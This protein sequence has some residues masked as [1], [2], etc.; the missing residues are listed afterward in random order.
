MAIEDRP[1]PAPHRLAAV[2]ADAHP[3]RP[4]LQVARGAEHVGRPAD[5]RLR[6]ARRRPEHVRV[7]AHPGH[8]GEVPVVDHADV[9]PAETALQRDL[10]AGRQVGGE[11]EVGGEEVAGAGRQ[12]R[13]RRLGADQRAQRRHHRSV[14]AA[15]EHDGGA[16]LD[17]RAGRPVAGILGRRLQP[18]RGR[19]TGAARAACTV[20][21]R[22]SRSST[23]A[24]LTTTADRGAGSTRRRCRRVPVGTCSCRVAGIGAPRSC[25][26][27]RAPAATGLGSLAMGSG[28]GPVRTSVRLPAWISRPRGSAGGVGQPAAGS[29]L[30]YAGGTKCGPPGVRTVSACEARPRLGRHRGDAAPS[31]RRRRATAGRR[32]AAE[33]HDR[34][35]DLAHAL[36]RLVRVD[37]EDLQV[38]GDLRG[39]VRAGRRRRCRPAGRAPR[40]GPGPG[41]RSGT[42]GSARTSGRSGRAA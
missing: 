40:T 6:L 3:H 25:P 39:V 18:P 17:G 38:A 1:R 37:P 20:S 28:A 21:R 22:L 31:P 32:A 30:A 13:H 7:E 24:G 12:D 10:D 4:V 14:A 5:A 35:L 11:P 9:E 33:R 34:L 41:T 8:H 36:E 2:D 16:V 42:W 29:S 26:F 19:P 27:R 23:F 15:D